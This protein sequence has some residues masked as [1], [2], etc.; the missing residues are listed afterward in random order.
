MRYLSGALY[1]SLLAHGW[2]VEQ[3]DAR[4]CWGPAEP[5]I[6]AWFKELLADVPGIKRMGV[7]EVFGPGTSL[8][9]IIAYIEANAPVPD[10][11]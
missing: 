9:D 6:P 8:R 5:K 4:V 1:D 7:G 2:L 10:A 11:W 3:P